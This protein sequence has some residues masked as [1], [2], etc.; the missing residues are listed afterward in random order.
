MTPGSHGG[1]HQKIAEIECLR[2]CVFEMFRDTML[3]VREPR[4]VSYGSCKD[5]CHV[6]C[7]SYLFHNKPTSTM[8]DENN[9]Y[10]V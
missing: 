7:D 8:S 6:F 2:E 9:G 3:G 1:G 5:A 10:L 4:V